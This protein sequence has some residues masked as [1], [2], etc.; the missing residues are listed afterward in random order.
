MGYDT[1]EKLASNEDKLYGYCLD[2][3]CE[4]SSYKSLGT[5]ERYLAYKSTGL[6]ID[7]TKTA[8][9][10]AEKFCL[11]SLNTYGNIPDCDGSDGRNLLTLD[12]Y[13]KLWNFEKGYYSFGTISLPNFQG[14][15]GGDTMNSMQTIFSVL[16][17][18]TL[19]KSDNS[20]LKHYQKNNYSFLDCLNIYC[21]YP[22]E[23]IFELQKTPEFVRY[24]NLY[25]TLGNM[26]LVPKRFNSGRYKKT[27]DFWDSSLVWL[28][29]NGYSYGNQLMF[30]KSDFTKY[31]NYF[32]LWDYVECV[33]GEYRIKPL[34][35]S[36]NNIE[37]GNVDN[38]SLWSNIAD[39]LNLK[40]F[41]SNACKNIKKRGVFMSILIRLKGSCNSNLKTLA[42]DYFNIIQGDF[43][44]AVHTDGYNDALMILLHLLDNY[45]DEVIKDAKAELLKLIDE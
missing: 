38:T 6:R 14:E 7:K 31:I 11:H 39:E 45:S 27:F 3:E 15:F 44:N 4:N 1:I 5:I 23:F 25:H 17:K 22:Q 36:H 26:V 10:K 41:L 9:T 2:F 37:M 34:F 21:D 24:A 18:F 29:S 32:F 8:L 43:I 35:D 30:N 16:M 13:K 19:K 33:N 12:I 20:K 28:K 42:D 40:Q